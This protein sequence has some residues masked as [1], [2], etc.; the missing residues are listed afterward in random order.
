MPLLSKDYLYGWWDACI[1]LVILETPTSYT[2]KE[3]EFYMNFSVESC[4]FK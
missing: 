2:I 3:G 4:E 1:G